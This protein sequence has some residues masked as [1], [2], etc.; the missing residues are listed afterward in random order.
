MFRQQKKSPDHQRAAG[1]FTVKTKKDPNVVF[2][3][4]VDDTGKILRAIITV[5]KT[6]KNKSVIK[7]IYESLNEKEHWIKD[8]HKPSLICI[9]G[10]KKNYADVMSIIERCIRTVIKP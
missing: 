7:S 6:S 1:T 5:Q 4:K 9:T 2:T 10:S 3:S 8:E